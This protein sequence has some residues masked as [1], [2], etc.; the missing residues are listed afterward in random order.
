M[1]WKKHESIESRLN[2]YFEQCDNFFGQFEKAFRLFLADGVTTTFGA[3]V[4]KAHQCESQADDLRRD[5]E[6]TLY[7][8]SL[9]PESRGD[10]LGLLETYDQ[11]PGAGEVVLFEML[12]QNMRVP[13]EFH[14]AFV[15]LVELNLQ[16]YFLVRKTVDA[17]MNNPRVTLGAVKEVDAKESQSDRQERKLIQEIF[18][19]AMDKADKLQLRSLIAGIS[20]ISDLAEHTADRIG[21]IAIKRQV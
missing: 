9:L 18:A 6:L 4:D 8:K 12:Y 2:R 13:P 19:S 21:I 16:A 10:L 7:G 15:R 1:F 3:E 17:L 14:P 11:L 5:I 20:R